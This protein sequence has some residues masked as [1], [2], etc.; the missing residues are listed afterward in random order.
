MQ[1]RN[2]GSS[3]DR[4][5]HFKKGSKLYWKGQGRLKHNETSNL[6]EVRSNV[7]GGQQGGYKK[8][9]KKG[10]E[11]AEGPLTLGGSTRAG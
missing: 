3:M 4:P 1:K 5:Q 6:S 9:N 11:G 10:S 7:V 8:M 2:Q